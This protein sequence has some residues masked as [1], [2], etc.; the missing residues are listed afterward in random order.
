MT[1]LE[2]LEIEPKEYED[3][4]DEMFENLSN[5]MEELPDEIHE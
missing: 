3:F 5:N 2:N 1:D 4:P